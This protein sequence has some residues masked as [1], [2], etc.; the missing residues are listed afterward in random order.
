MNTLPDELIAHTFLLGLPPLTDDLRS[1]HE[2][3]AR[4][5]RHYLGSIILVCKLWTSISMSTPRLWT[6]IYC[7]PNDPKSSF[8]LDG[9]AHWPHL[10]SFLARSKDLPL[11]VSLD[12]VTWPQYESELLEHS[13]RITTLDVNNVS[14][15]ELIEKGTWHNLR[16]LHLMNYDSR[17]YMPSRDVDGESTKGTD[18][19]TAKALSA[20]KSLTFSVGRSEEG[21][22]FGFSLT[23]MTVLRSYVEPMFLEHIT[24]HGNNLQHFIPYLGGFHNLRTL[25]IEQCK[26][27]R[28]I[29][30]EALP[31]IVGSIELEC[32]VEVLHQEQMGAI[33]DSITRLEVFYN[34]ISAAPYTEDTFWQPV[35]E[36]P[37]LETLIL[38][39][40][41]RV[42]KP[43]IEHLLRNATA[44]KV[45]EI[46]TKILSRVSLDGATI[47]QHICNS[48][49]MSPALNHIILSFVETPNPEGLA[50]LRVLLKSRSSLRITLARKIDESDGAILGV[51]SEEEYQKN[52]DYEAYTS[53]RSEF[54]GRLT[55][56]LE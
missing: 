46:R 40:F 21:R 26:T 35:P 5:T 25:R 43:G 41:D 19:V 36:F 15:F 33:S 4:Q 31:L 22:S 34:G 8:L 55:I 7:G 28:H 52:E 42:A 18:T 38:T 56:K 53:L 6:V 44:L 23:A 3:A 29:P 37:Q 54:G 49:P 11:H 27:L 50:V 12:G 48:L 47:L 1:S 13:K 32:D 51:V 10:R 24:I 2:K 17:L 9:E 20:L 30:I 16:H 45:L 39:L 14:T